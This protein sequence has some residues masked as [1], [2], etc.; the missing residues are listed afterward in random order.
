MKTIFDVGAHQ[1]EDTDFYLKKGF[2]VVAFEANP[3]LAQQLRERF[4][5]Y[6]STGRLTLIEG[7][8]ADHD[9]EVEFYVNE[10]SVWGTAHKNWAERN[11]KMGKPSTSISVRAV[12]FTRLIEEYGIPYYLK[13]DIE[14]SDMLCVQALAQVPAR[15]S[16][17][18]I[19]SSKTSWK[20]LLLE[21]AM[22]ERLGYQRF[23]VINQSRVTD[24]VEPNPPREGNFTDHTFPPHSS[25]L[26]GNELPGPWLTKRQALARYALIF[27]QYRL[28]GDNTIGKRIARRMPA[29][30]RRRLIP[31][32]FDTH[33]A[34]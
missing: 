10:L 29:F 18:S 7:A 9:G 21:F 24:Q 25:G 6:L 4:S 31:G 15:P 16:F 1:G 34:L 32:W 30:L 28:F 3:V 33:A 2:N 23:K 12:S 22:F 27:V 26:F 19:E 5:S 20:E 14:G 13:I 11:Q 17:I 8:V